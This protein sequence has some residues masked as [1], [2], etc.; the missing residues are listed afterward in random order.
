[1][2]CSSHSGGGDSV[3]QLLRQRRKEQ[4]PWVDRTDWP[5]IPCLEGIEGRVPLN[6]YMQGCD[7]LRTKQIM[8][9]IN[10]SRRALHTS[11]RCPF[12]GKR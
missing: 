8:N 1:M 9:I 3:E 12:I 2:D 5:R 4:T 10:S 7:Y 6:L 11:Y